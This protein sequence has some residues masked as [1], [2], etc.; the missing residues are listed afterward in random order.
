M[1][2]TVLYLFWR[3]ESSVGSAENRTPDGA[4]TVPTELLRAVLPVELHRKPDGLHIA[5]CPCGQCGHARYRRCDKEPSI[6][7]HVPSKRRST[8]CPSLGP[9]Q[10][11]VPCDC[12]SSLLQ[13]CGCNTETGSASAA[14]HFRTFVREILTG[15]IFKVFVFHA[16]QLH[17]PFKHLFYPNY[18]THT[19]THT[20]THTHTHT[21]YVQLRRRALL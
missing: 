3:G 15:I 12:H 6:S 19:H 7:C 20:L 1:P 10:T 4:A 5:V 9:D 13:V 8:E 18:T 16:T 21:Q 14:A 11:V 2:R 17:A